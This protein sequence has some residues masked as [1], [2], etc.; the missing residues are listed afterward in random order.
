MQ[1]IRLHPDRVKKVLQENTAETFGEGE[2]PE[3]IRG[4]ANSIFSEIEDCPVL[5]S[6]NKF[7]HITGGTKE[8]L[9]K[10]SSC[11]IFFQFGDD[12][13]RTQ[14]GRS[15]IINLDDLAY[16]AK[17]SNC[18]DTIQDCIKALYSVKEELPNFLR[19]AC[20]V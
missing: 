15:V 11:R 4:L 5:S 1:P 19:T 20:K 10:V 9:P 2:I 16:E 18:I 7:V 14:W 17:F 13:T 6:G 12:E 8:L 3:Q